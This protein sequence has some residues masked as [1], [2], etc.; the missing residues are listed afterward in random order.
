MSPPQHRGRQ[1]SGE[2][3]GLHCIRPVSG[4]QINYLI[5]VAGAASDWQHMAAAPDFPFTWLVEMSQH[6]RQEG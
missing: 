3:V 1:E 5:T 4:F 6:L 2:T